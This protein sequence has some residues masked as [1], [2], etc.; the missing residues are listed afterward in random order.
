MAW[1]AQHNCG[2]TAEK[3]NKT[4]LFIKRVH[5]VSR[6]ILKEQRSRMASKGS[7]EGRFVFVFCHPKCIPDICLHTCKRLALR[8]S[9]HPLHHT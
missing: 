7:S 9:T 4:N 6:S 8:T 5:Q 3:Q 2:V 1:A